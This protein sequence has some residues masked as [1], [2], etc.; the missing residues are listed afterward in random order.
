MLFTSFKGNTL[1]NDAFILRKLSWKRSRCHLNKLSLIFSICWLFFHKNDSNWT[2]IYSCFQGPTGER[3][4]PG[5]AGAIGQP[6]RAG[7][8][9]GAGPMGDKGEPVITPFV[10]CWVFQYWCCMLFFSLLIAAVGTKIHNV[11]LNVLKLVIMSKMTPLVILNIY[12]VQYTD[13]PVD[14]SLIPKFRFVKST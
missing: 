6:G 8:L 11:I 7:V 4:A 9:G 1:I 5:P 2:S 3:G 14:R 13:I 12:T 10:C